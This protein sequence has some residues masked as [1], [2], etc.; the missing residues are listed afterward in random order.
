MWRHVG[1]MSGNPNIMGMNSAFYLCNLF[2]FAFYYV[3]IKVF[4]HINCNFALFLLV[5]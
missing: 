5:G 4:D 2:Y 3:V 1:V